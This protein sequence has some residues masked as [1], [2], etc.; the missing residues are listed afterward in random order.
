MR[1]AGLPWQPRLA[2]VN[3][4]SEVTAVKLADESSKKKC[5]QRIECSYVNK[6]NWKHH[7]LNRVQ[8]RN[9]VKCD[10]FESTTEAAQNGGQND[11]RKRLKSK[12]SLEEISEITY[13]VSG[14]F[15]VKRNKNCAT[16][17]RNLS[18]VRAFK[19]KSIHF[20]SEMR[21]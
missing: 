21:R 12:M 20:G 15:K 17:S 7:E 9:V 14:G 18:L 5:I 11:R 6:K 16:I 13:K 19:W 4:R 8:V 10:D 2:G 1:Q 3:D